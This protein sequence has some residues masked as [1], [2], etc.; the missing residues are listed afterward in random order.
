MNT[1]L[2][3]L[4]SVRITVVCLF[5]LFVLTFWG[6]V[7]QVQQGLYAAQE[8]FFNSFFFLAAG[9]IPFPG[10]QLVL[11][12]LFINLL[13][14]TIIRFSKYRKWSYAGVLIIHFGLLLYFTAAFIIFH[15]AK[16]SNIHL[17]EGEATNVSQSYSEWE[18]A[19]WK[20]KGNTHEVTAFDSKFFSPGFHI[21]F[22]D[23]NF[24]IAVKQF[25]T[26]TVAFTN[27]ERKSSKIINIS[28]ISML[29]PKPLIKERE[30]NIA[31]GIFDLKIKG[32][33]YTLILFG[34]E[35]HPTPVPI[36]GKVYYFSLRHKRTPL[37]FTIHLDQ[38]KAEFHPGTSV[39]KSYESYVTVKTGSS[40][41][42]V[43]IFMN[44]P[45]RYKDYTVYQASYD[46]DQAGRQY[47][48][49]AVVKNFAKM[50]PYVA[51][52]VVFFG[53]ALHFLLQ[54][55]LSRPKV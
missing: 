4:S 1:I 18:L 55:F 24:S 27:S 39:A 54:A 12:V 32:K 25:Y 33:S 43:R 41:R 7:A 14:T 42:Q 10:A 53:L 46:I 52:F 5:L 13:C 44:N 48:T 36:A 51:C 2:K 29:E 38:F 22:S 23:T 16:E 50:L 35:T 34:A 3:A 47:S 45:L 15:V 19:Y 8:R 9:Y 40:E 28:G 6:T 21:P 17:M 49:L 20:E 31:G 26:N 11:W 37:P 30:K